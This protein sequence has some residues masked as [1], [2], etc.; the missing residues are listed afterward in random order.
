MSA[1][2]LALCCLWNPVVSYAWTGSIGSAGPSVV[3]YLKSDTAQPAGPLEHMK[4]E[5]TALLNSP[6]YR[7]EW[8][9][10]ASR[11]RNVDNAELVVLELRGSCGVPAGWL[12]GTSHGSSG[13]L[14]STSVA[15]GRI[16]PFTWVDCENLTRMVASAVAGEEPAQR[17]YL[18]GRAMARLVAHELYHVLARTREHSRE[19]IGKAGFTVKELLADRFEFARRDQIILSGSSMGSF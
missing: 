8:R 9:D 11:E 15:N 16:I 4:L 12:P 2:L 5:V 3:V 17:D 13:S 18:Y 10:A 7:V 19:G 6:G 1:R 14:A